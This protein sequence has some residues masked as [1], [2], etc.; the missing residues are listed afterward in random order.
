VIAFIIA[1]IAVVVVRPLQH[2]KPTTHGVRREVGEGT[3]A[4]QR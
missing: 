1:S 4:A 3:T 2:V